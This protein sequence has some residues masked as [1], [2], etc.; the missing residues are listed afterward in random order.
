MAKRVSLGEYQARVAERLRSLSEQ[1]AVASKL[2]F[3]LAGKNWLIDLTAVS[4]VLPVPSIV[5]VPMTQPW[6]RGAANIRGNL[7]SVVDFSAFQGGSPILSGLES[8]LLLIN[9]RLIIGSALLVGRMVGLR[10]LDLLQPM[11][12]PDNAPPWLRAVYADADGAVWQD[13]NIDALIKAPWF[14]DAGTHN[15]ITNH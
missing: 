4:E 7:Y 3:Q 5:P 11:Q 6:F 2:G 9:Q 15:P 10:N 13:L 8:R 14:L 1:T 12:Q